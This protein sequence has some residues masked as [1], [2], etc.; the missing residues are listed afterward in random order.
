[1]GKKWTPGTPAPSK[2]M[3]QSNNRITKESSWVW[4]RCA[5]QESVCSPCP[6]TPAGSG[7]IWGEDWKGRPV[8][9][10]PGEFLFSGTRPKHPTSEAKDFSIHPFIQGDARSAWAPYMPG[11]RKGLREGQRAGPSASR[12]LCFPLPRVADL[13]A[14]LIGARKAQPHLFISTLRLFATGQA[15]VGCRIMARCRRL[16][17]AVQASGN[18][19]QVTRRFKFSSSQFKEKKK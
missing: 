2:W 18:R 15:G 11:S 14:R 12:C 1:M 4:I 10:A 8:N 9:A 3:S 13:H 19:M 17:R 5:L 6:C 16:H 7:P